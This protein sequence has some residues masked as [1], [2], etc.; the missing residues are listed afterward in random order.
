MDT[1]QTRNSQTARIGWRQYEET[2]LQ[3]LGKLKDD[4]S[5]F[6]K[7]FERKTVIVALGRGG[8]VPAVW[9]SHRLGI[10]NVA[11]IPVTAYDGRNIRKPRIHAGDNDIWFGSFIRSQSD[12]DIHDTI[13][14]VDDLI[15]SGQTIMFVRDSLALAYEMDSLPVP[16]ISTAVV[17]NKTVQGRTI[18]P[19]HYGA[20]IAESLWVV[21]PYEY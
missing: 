9:L 3:L 15:D 18:Q 6:S 21:F 8:M 14:L 10:E 1:E 5:I 19:R 4:C 12:L 20:H 17:F 16:D 11:H 13:L 7:V 2:M